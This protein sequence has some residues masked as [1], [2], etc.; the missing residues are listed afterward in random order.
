[1]DPEVANDVFG[2]AFLVMLLQ[3][4]DSLIVVMFFSFL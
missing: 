3:S 4:W 1:M 2:E